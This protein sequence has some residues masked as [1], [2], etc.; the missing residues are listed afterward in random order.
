MFS[1]QSAGFNCLKE[2]P[3]VL[4]GD[5]KFN[6]KSHEYEKN[7]F[8]RILELISARFAGVHVFSQPNISKKT[9]DDTFPDC[10]IF[11]HQKK[12]LLTFLAVINLIINELLAL[13]NS[14]H[15]MPELYLSIPAKVKDSY[16]EIEA[17]NIYQEYYTSLN[18]T[19]SEQ[20][21]PVKGLYVK[22]L[23]KSFEK[24]FE[25]INLVFG[26]KGARNILIGGI[27]ICKQ[28]LEPAS[29]KYLEPLDFIS[30]IVTPRLQYPPDVAA[31]HSIN[32][33]QEYEAKAR[34]LGLTSPITCSILYEIAPGEMNAVE[35]ILAYSK[36][37]C[38]IVGEASRDKNLPKIIMDTVI[39][40]PLTISQWDTLPNTSN[41]IVGWWRR[42]H[43]TSLKQGAFV[44]RVE[45]VS[46]SKVSFYCKR[47]CSICEKSSDCC[48]GTCT[49]DSVLNSSLVCRFNST[50]CEPHSSSLDFKKVENF[51][52]SQSP[53]LNSPSAMEVPNYVTSTSL[54]YVL[55]CTTFG[56][57]VVICLLVFYYVS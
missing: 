8:I 41:R 26:K 4:D 45:E 18:K 35:S 28:F 31:Q 15:K 30:C 42:T 7:D 54:Q 22:P 11:I 2:A 17:K 10:S 13:K 27:F 32:L 14:T 16:T 5:F 47:L 6:F 51:K 23:T 56:C 19:V 55:A 36:F 9:V 12:F 57:I 43:P 1:L 24:H 44:E 48:I 38:T 50:I 40:P 20:Q 52:A 29:I 46:T 3:G 39:E 53:P 25:I 34:R 21:K 37:W 49:S 33:C